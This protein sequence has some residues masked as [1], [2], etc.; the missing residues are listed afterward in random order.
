[1][2][3]YRVCIRSVFEKII[4]PYEVCIFVNTGPYEKMAALP[5]PVSGKK[6]EKTKNDLRAMKQILYDMGL[7]AHVRCLL[8][9]AFKFEPPFG[10]G[11]EL[12][13]V[14]PPPKN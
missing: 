6:N 13:R 5:P 14:P 10:P 11:S 2:S 4:G 3:Q 8:D 9:K 1:M 12:K 7:L